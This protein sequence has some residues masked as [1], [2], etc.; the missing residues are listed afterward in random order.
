M[1]ASR[2]LLFSYAHATEKLRVFLPR[3][4]ACVC[5]WLLQMILAKVQIYCYYVRL[6][7]PLRRLFTRQLVKWQ[8]SVNRL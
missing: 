3:K 1:V 8:S 5:P 2:P 6:T 4:L 7:N